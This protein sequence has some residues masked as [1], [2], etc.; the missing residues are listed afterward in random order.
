MSNIDCGSC[1]DLRSYAPSFV[2]NGITNKICNSLAN[3]TGLNPDLTTLHNDCDDLKDVNDCLVGRMDGELEAH[4][5]CD[6]KTFMHKFIP[7]LYETIKGM[8]CSMCGQWKRIEKLECEIAYLYKG[9]TFYIHETPSQGSYVVAGK[10]VSYA[11]IHGDQERGSDIFIRYIAGGYAQMSGSCRFYTDDFTDDDAI[12]NYDDETAVDPTLSANRLGN[13]YWGATGRTSTGG[14]LIYE[15]RIK[16]SVYPQVNRIFGGSGLE[17]NGGAFHV[18]ALVFTEGSYAYGQHGS[19][20]P[21]DGTPDDPSY[22]PGH[23]VPDGWIYVQCR[24]SYSDIP[25][26]TSTGAQRSPFLHMGIRIARE[27]IDC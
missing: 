9:A 27:A 5:V 13:A 18:R 3:N 25:L 12:Y 21:S 23:L 7:N 1:N 11:L 10:G 20:D 16:K 22:S 14:E 2:Q 15:I 4:E 24:Q 19:C 17:S 8:I 6:W 26:G